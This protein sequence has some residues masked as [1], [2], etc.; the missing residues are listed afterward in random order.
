MGVPVAVK[1]VPIPS[2]PNAAKG[3]DI[4]PDGVGMSLSTDQLAKW[5][6]TSRAFVREFNNLRGLQHP[7]IIQFFGAVVD[8]GHV[9]DMFEIESMED[10][11]V[12][13]LHKRVGDVNLDTLAQYTTPVKQQQQTQVRHVVR[14][15][16]RLLVMEMAR[17]SLR[18]VLKS[19]W[20]ERGGSGD[21]GQENPEE[22]TRSSSSGPEESQGGISM[23]TCLNWAREVASALVYIHRRQMAHLDVK[24]RERN[25]NNMSVCECVS[26]CG[27]GG[28]E[29]G[30]LHTH[31]W[32]CL[33]FVSYLACKCCHCSHWGGQVM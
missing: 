27:G 4:R 18:D 33:T 7:H 3:E 1:E 13:S 8:K 16:T 26:A 32:H 29:M 5:E 12:K 2:I 14:P 20:G 24:V 10:I 17:C 31:T 23:L 30:V 19:Q 11:A 28:W 21:V 15:P 22:A 9:T 6:K 25:A